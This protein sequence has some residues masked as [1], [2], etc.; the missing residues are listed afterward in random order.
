MPRFGLKAREAPRKARAPIRL[1]WGQTDA[2]SLP[3]DPATFEKVDETFKQG[4]GKKALLVCRGGACG[5]GA[6]TPIP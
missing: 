2:V 1:V 5:E 4:S 6:L 3:L